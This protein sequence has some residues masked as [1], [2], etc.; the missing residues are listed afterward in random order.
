MTEYDHWAPPIHYRSGI[1]KMGL[2]LLLSD[3]T[4]KPCNISQITSTF[5]VEILTASVIDYL[6][7]KFDTADDE[8]NGWAGNL[9]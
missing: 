8:L 7:K 1:R 5:K 6:I 4:R 2:H 9:L 3:C